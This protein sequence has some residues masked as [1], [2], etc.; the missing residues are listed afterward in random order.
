MWRN[1]E[2]YN[3]IKHEVKALW[4]GVEGSCFIP[5]NDCPFESYYTDSSVVM[6]CGIHNEYGGLP[7][8]MGS[9][10]SMSAP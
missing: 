6:A 1:A 9:T 7:M 3:S 10:M 5:K 4:A 8:G 2:S